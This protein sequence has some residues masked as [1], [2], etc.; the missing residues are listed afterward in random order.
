MRR[1]AGVLHERRPPRRQV[2]F[3]PVAEPAGPR[4]YVGVLGDAELG[5]RAADEV[6]V[7]VRRAGH[8]HGIDGLPA[9]LTQ[10]LLRSVDGE[11]EA[12]RRPRRQID[13]A[14]ELLILVAAD[15]GEAFDL[16]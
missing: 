14:H 6:A 9:V 12:L 5:L 15:V 3:G 11:L 4:R 13:E 1:P 16:P 2:A 10:Q 8:A 7:L